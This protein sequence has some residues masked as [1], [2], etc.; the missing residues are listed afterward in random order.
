MV[1]REKSSALCI[2]DN[3]RYQEEVAFYKEKP[4]EAGFIHPELRNDGI[5][6]ENFL[7][8]KVIFITGATGFF[9]KGTYIYIYIY[10]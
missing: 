6:V 2:E 4:L 3:E 1:K 7:Q 10:T 9:A 5:G 8:G